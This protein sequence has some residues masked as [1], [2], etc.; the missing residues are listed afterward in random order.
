MVRTIE[1]ASATMMIK[2]DERIFTN[3]A[4]VSP[5]RPR[6]A[7]NATPANIAQASTDN[8][9]RSHRTTFAQGPIRSTPVQLLRTPP[10]AL[11]GATKKPAATK[12]MA[13]MT[14]DESATL[15]VGQRSSPNSP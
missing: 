13:Q 12:M 6:S 10:P 9:A 11:V 14:T 5:H 8:T 7:K 1:D 2:L 4:T 15:N 3:G